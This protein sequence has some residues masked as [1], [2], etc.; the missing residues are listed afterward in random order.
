MTYVINRY[1]GSILTSVEDGTL[2]QITEVKLVGKN[3]AG[4]GEAQNENFLH[5]MENFSGAAPPLKPLSGMIWYD[6]TLGR[7]KFF[8]GV[9]WKSAGTAEVSSIEPANVSTGD[10]WWNT[11]TNQMF[12]RSVNNEW[13]L[14]GPQST[15]EKVTQMVSLRL[16]GSDGISRSVIASTIDDDVLYIISDE[17]FTIGN[18]TPVFG[19]SV[20]KRGITFGNATSSGVTATS[21]TGSSEAIMWGTASNSLQLGGVDAASFVKTTDQLNYGDSGF[22]VGDSNDLRLYVESTA[23][24]IENTT[25]EQIQFIIKDESAKH[26]ATINQ[27][28]L[29]PATTDTYDIGAISLRWKTVYANTF[30]GV[31][32]QSDTLKEGS[33]YRSAAVAST[34]NTVAVRGGLGELNA[35]LFNGVATSAM[36][37]DLA[38]KYKTDKPLSVG[39]VVA[40]CE[41]PDHE[42]SPCDETQLPVGVV[43]ENPAF[44]MN[45]EAE[46]QYI[47][48]KGRVP[49]RVLGPVRKGDSVYANKNGVCTTEPSVGIV[50]VVLETNLSTSEKLVECV[51]KV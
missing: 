18:E 26:I 1:D 28:G 6:A 11:A 50:G 45:C 33:S 46:G 37:A 24:V 25:G 32:T 51:L 41:C 9:R 5:L 38:E 14:V 19:F 8:D 4:Y 16:V 30:D 21:L 31:A 13:I 7:I 42:V 20:I 23:A 3:Y 47:A 2:N 48:L 36:Y 43:S 40:V 27:I 10:V 49:V 35:T 15:G 39:T 29:V 22:F 34:A 44:M 17:E 12:A